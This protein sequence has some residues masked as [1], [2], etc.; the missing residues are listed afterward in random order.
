MH[1]GMGVRNRATEAAEQPIS[2]ACNLVG[3]SHQPFR[4]IHHDQP[5]A[6]TPISHDQ[7]DGH[8]WTIINHHEP[9]ANQP[10]INIQCGE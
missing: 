4:T 10:S 9:S 5:A 3:I 7:M 6:T 8:G 1:F 2:D